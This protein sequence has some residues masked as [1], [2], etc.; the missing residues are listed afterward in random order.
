MVIVKF[1]TDIYVNTIF[2]IAQKLYLKSSKHQTEKKIKR[3]RVIV[4]FIIALLVIIES[5]TVILYRISYFWPN[6]KVQDV[7]TSSVSYVVIP[8]VETITFIAF[9]KLFNLAPVKK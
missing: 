9:M 2:F 3:N 6:T 1:V 8:I 5:I 7:I 4:T